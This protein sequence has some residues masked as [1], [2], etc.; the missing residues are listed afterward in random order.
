M[1]KYTTYRIGR[2]QT[3]EI[4]IDDPTVSRLHAEL[5]VSAGGKCYLT[6]CCS[7]GGSFVAV[8]GEWQSIVQAFVDQD[9]YVLLGGHQATIGE[10]LSTARVELQRTPQPHQTSD[11]RADTGPLRRDPV[12]GE[13]LG[14]G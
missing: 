6:D 3:C 9:Q 11:E 2:S 1:A 7:S 12:T 14:R 13:I 5:V 4:V 10:L 8:E